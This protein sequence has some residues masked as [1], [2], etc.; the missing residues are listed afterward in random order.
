M[1]S[2]V[3]DHVHQVLDCILLVTR[4]DQPSPACE[5]DC[6]ERHRQRIRTPPGLRRLHPTGNPN[7]SKLPSHA[8]GLQTHHGFAL[9]WVNFWLMRVIHCL[10]L[11]AVITPRP[12]REMR[13]L[14]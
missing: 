14:M 3:H 13:E 10:P 9:V 7:N 8:E 12:E 6:L 1:R 4:D 11:H 2:A 5:R